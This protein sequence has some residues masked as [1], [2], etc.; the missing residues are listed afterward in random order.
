MQLCVRAQRIARVLHEPRFASEAG[1][2]PTIEL[3]LDSKFHAPISSGLTN[4]TPAKTPGAPCSLGR[5]EAP[6]GRH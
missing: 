1:S 6:P 3:Q 4:I 5:V 2:A